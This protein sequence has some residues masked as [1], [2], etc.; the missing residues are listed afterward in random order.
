[1]NF[2]WKEPALGPSE[3]LLEAGVAY[4]PLY[5]LK[6]LLSVLHWAGGRTSSAQA[7]NAGETCP[8]GCQGG[9]GLLLWEFLLGS[10]EVGASPWMLGHIYL[11]A[12]LPQTL[13]PP[14]PTCH[15]HLAPLS[16]LA[17]TVARPLA[18]TPAAPCAQTCLTQQLWAAI[19]LTFCPAHENLIS[20]RESSTEAPFCLDTTVMGEGSSVSPN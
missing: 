18:V 7:G 16:S 3:P 17:S 20:A 4:P 1:M 8:D 10:F 11:Q 19:P 5:Y 9:L 2:R 12:M 14:G 13:W 6:W 15:L